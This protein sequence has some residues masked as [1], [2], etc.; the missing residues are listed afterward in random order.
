MP[1]LLTVRDPADLHQ[2]IT[3]SGLKVSFISRKCGI[4][5]ERLRTLRTG[6]QPRIAADAAAVLEDLLRVDRGTLFV[7]DGADTVDL[8]P[9]AD[10]APAEA[11]S[12]R[13]HE[14]TAGVR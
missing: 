4:G 12:S 7:L 8:T 2:R 11:T 10:P 6:A 13:A 14:P 1:T 5:R 9:Y 3:D